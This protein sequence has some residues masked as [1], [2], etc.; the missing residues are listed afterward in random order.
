MQMFEMFELKTQNGIEAGEMKNW[1]SKS[2]M[3]KKT[4]LD[5]VLIM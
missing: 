2:E 5:R 4:V 1:V 3:K